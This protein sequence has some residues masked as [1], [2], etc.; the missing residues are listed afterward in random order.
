MTST[1]PINKLSQHVYNECSDLPK[2]P[3]LF[4]CD[5]CDRW[6]NRMHATHF[7][8][9]SRLVR[10]ELSSRYRCSRGKRG[11]GPIRIRIICNLSTESRSKNSMGSQCDVL[12]CL[13]ISNVAKSTRTRKNCPASGS[14]ENA[15]IKKRRAQ[16]ILAKLDVEKK[17]ESLN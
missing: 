7:K 12:Q 9:R 8:E 16:S 17:Q 10:S 3:P 1:R 6:R 5:S 2:L 13:P 14:S 4:S 15:F 11:H